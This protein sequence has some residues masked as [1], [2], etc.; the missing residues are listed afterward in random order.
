MLSSK[1]TATLLYA[2]PA[3]RHLADTYKRKINYLMSFDYNVHSSVAEAVFDEIYNARVKIEN[4]L[5]LANA[6]NTAVGLLNDD[7]KAVIAATYFKGWS[8]EKVARRLGISISLASSRRAY[9]FHKLRN[10]IETLGFP[11]SRIIEYFDS[12]RLFIDIYE[13]VSERQGKR[14]NFI[15]GKDDREK[16]KTA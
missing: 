8:K 12:E 16:R 14:T 10:Y 6:I 2:G 13:R 11:E 9:A 7:Q 1:M 3:L 5:A 4:I 15:L